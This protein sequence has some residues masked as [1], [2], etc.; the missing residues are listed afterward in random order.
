MAF[1]G[2]IVADGVRRY[3]DERRERI[4]PFVDRNFSLRGSIALHR[5]AVGWDIAR[6]PLNLTMAAPQV[7]LLLAAGAAGR[8]GRDARGGSSR[9]QAAGR[10][11]RSR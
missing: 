10:A 6:A 11:Y 4:G 8:L 1:A 5:A 3:F 2:Q 9:Q 7:G